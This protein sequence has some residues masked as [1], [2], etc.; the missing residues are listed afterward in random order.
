MS[1]SDTSILTTYYENNLIVCDKCIFLEN[2]A[3]YAIHVS[4]SAY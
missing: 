3:L 2:K 1:T 4:N